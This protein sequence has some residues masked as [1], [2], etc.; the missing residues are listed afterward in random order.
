LQ[1]CNLTLSGAAAVTTAV[2]KQPAHTMTLDGRSGGLLTHSSY[3][4]TREY[5]MQS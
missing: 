1:V 5:V 2:G 3:T 4:T